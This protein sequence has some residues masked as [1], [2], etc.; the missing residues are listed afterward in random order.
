MKINFFN[1]I[2]FLWQKLFLRW[3]I[4]IIKNYFS[5]KFFLKIEF[6]PFWKRHLKWPLLSSVDFLNWQKNVSWISS[7]RKIRIHKV[8]RSRYFLC[9]FKALWRWKQFEFKSW[10]VREINFCWVFFTL[11]KFS[12]SWTEYFFREKYFT[13]RFFSSEKIL[14]SLFMILVLKNYFFSKCWRSP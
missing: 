6:L 9:K 12:E 7:D 5:S 4:Q 10:I 14:D 11:W 2:F 8:L 3:M 1:S 13:F